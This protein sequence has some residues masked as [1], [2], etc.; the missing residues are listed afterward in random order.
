[1]NDKI[2]FGVLVYLILST[3]ISAMMPTSM[4]TGTKFEVLDSQTVKESVD[5][6]EDVLVGSDEPLSF[7]QKI[8]TYFFVT[9]N[10]NGI[11]SLIALIIFLFNIVVVMVGA[12]YVYDKIRGIGS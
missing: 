12:V 7:V 6:S 1:M 11:P 8:L 10:I 5:S 9:W 4:Y 3:G 2:F